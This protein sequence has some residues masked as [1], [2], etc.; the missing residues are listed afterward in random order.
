MSL[1]TI[2]VAG[3]K[4]PEGPRWHDGALWFSDQCGGAVR[5]LESDGT[6]VT[7]AAVDW[8]SGLGF[9]SDGDLLVATMNSCEVLR[10]ASS[11]A[12][13]RYAD[14][15]S[16]GAHLN[17]MYVGPDDRAYV[18][19][20]RED[21]RTGAI[22]MI[23]GDSISVVATDLAFPNGLAITPDDRTL[24]VSETYGERLT[25]YDVATNGLLSNRRIWASL[26]GRYPDGLCLDAG[27]AVWVAS[28]R[29]DEFI[30]V[31]EGGEIVDTVNAAGGWAL[32]PCLG[33][34][35]ARTLYLCSS[36]TNNARYLAG[37]AEGYLAAVTVEIPGVARP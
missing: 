7:V 22:V 24:I 33:G 29:S 5:R 16:H 31:R 27:G 6:A 9:R 3:L 12:V 36:R 11:G 21:W 17:D 19:V 37:D 2:D 23:D 35:D 15:S 30:R 10:V 4:F 34:D 25:A 32:A 18:D 13:S 20:Y 1:T 14:L 8:P 26:P 28:Y